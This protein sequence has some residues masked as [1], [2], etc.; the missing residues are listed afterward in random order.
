MLQIVIVRKIQRAYREADWEPPRVRGTLWVRQ[1][2]EALEVI[3]SGEERGAR[4][5][6]K[7]HEP[8]CRHK[9]RALADVVPPARRLGRPPLR[10]IDCLGTIIQGGLARFGFG[11]WRLLALDGAI[12]GQRQCDSRRDKTTPESGS[13]EPPHRASPLSGCAQARA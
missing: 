13:V 6:L 8:L 1:E 10:K 9:D 12:N 2:A 11:L 7:R 3:G 5:L 4:G